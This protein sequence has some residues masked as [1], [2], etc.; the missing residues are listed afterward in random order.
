[1]VVFARDP[2]PGRVKTRLAAAIG[3]DQATALYT[4]MVTDLLEMWMQQAV[5]WDTEIH[6]DRHS[7]FYD[8]FGVPTHL[9][10]G[11]G[12]GEKLYHSIFNGLAQSHPAVAIIGSDAPTLRPEWLESLVAQPEDVVLGPTDDGG[13]WGILAR[14][15]APTM[16]DGV[17]WSTADTLHDTARACRSASLS[18]G[19]GVQGW[20]VDE[21]RDLTRLQQQGAPGPHLQRFLA[22]LPADSSPTQPDNPTQP[23]NPVQR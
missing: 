22:A 20:D 10:Q 4:A 19:F 15:V 8:R 5:S 6:L 14:R 7:F 1:L 12:L 13:F 11:E 23:G 16:F 9:Q 17:G 18:V 21:A 2:V 3:S